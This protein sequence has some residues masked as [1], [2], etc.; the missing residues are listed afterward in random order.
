VI[1]VACVERGRRNLS[2]T[3]IT[4]VLRCTRRAN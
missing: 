3:L 1:S 4:F 2:A